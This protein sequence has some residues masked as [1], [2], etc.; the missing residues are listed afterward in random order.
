MRIYSV[1]NTNYIRSTDTASIL[2]IFITEN[3]GTPVNLTSYSKVE[4]AIGNEVG[5]IIT[6]TPLSKGA[7]GRLTFKFTS[8]TSLTNGKYY[9][10]VHLTTN[11]TSNEKK[12]AP[13]R[14]TFFIEIAKS[15][16]EP[17]NNNILI[18]TVNIDYLKQ[19][20]EQSQN[21]TLRVADYLAK[22]DEVYN[23]SLPLRVNA[24]NGNRLE[25]YTKNT[26]TWS[27]VQGQLPEVLDLGT[28]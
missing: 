24:S 21:N 9:L 25:Y 15:L 19:L 23:Q 16:D 27:T 22:F 10:E 4:V 14:S 28:F 11:T 8:A 26:N 17:L 6:L 3:N 2:E 18:E 13:S 5:R 12:V 1:D 7:D 20:M